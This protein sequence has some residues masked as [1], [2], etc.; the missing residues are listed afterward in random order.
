[1]SQFTYEFAEQKTPLE[2]YE[3]DNIWIEQ[4]GNNI[5]NRVLY[6]GDSISCGTRRIATEVSGNKC[7]FDGFGTSKALDNPFLFD[8]IHLFAQQLTKI[9][10]VIFNN[11]L[12]GWHL[13]DETEYRE[14]YENAI[15]FLLEEF[16][17]KKIFLVLTTSVA[18]A[19][20]EARVKA[21]NDVVK[22]LAEKYN[23][24]IIDLYSTAVE[25][26]SLRCDDG[27][28]Y[29]GVGYNKFAAKILEIMKAE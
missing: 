28:H 10:T 20:R 14:C 2:T 6:I 15:K 23:L 5:A 1:M 25:Y 24:P 8:A 17:G 4:T 18:D 7:L 16:D 19:E 27:V 9:E 11:G 3:W 21:R 26:A 22:K 12:H 13:K 29:S